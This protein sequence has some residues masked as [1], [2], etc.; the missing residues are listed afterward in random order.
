M[1]GSD[2]EAPPTNLQA[3]CKDAQQCNN[4]HVATTFTDRPHSP[5][6]LV[7]GAVQNQS[8]N[9][10]RVATAVATQS[11]EDRADHHEEGSQAEVSKQDAII[12]GIESYLDKSTMERSHSPGTVVTGAVQAQSADQSKA[13]T[14][15]TTQSAKDRSP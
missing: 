8:A 4:Q 11:A 5:D 7:T 6:T 2:T 15:V 13:A 9:Q 10:L 1:S 3:N 12:S 14:A